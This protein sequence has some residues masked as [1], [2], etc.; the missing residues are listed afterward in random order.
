V[1]PNAVYFPGGR[2]GYRTPQGYVFGREGTLDVTRGDP[3]LALPRG[4]S[5][6]TWPVAVV[7][8]KTFLLYA[9]GT[10]QDRI[11]LYRVRVGADALTAAALLP[12]SNRPIGHVVVSPD[13]RKIAFNGP[14]GVYIASLDHRSEPQRV[15]TATAQLLAWL[16]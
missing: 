16:P 13:H 7:D 3:A 12:D 4:V 6:Y 5:A 14:D 15:A 1:D 9:D 2:M 10:G 11:Q 8:D